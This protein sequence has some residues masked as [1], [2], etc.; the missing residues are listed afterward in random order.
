MATLVNVVICRSEDLFG[1]QTN[2]Y[3]D[4]DRPRSWLEVAK[5]VNRYL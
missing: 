2:N 3:S 5:V 1:L 4:Q